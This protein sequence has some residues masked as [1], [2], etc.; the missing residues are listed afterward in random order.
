MT[1]KHEVETILTKLGVPTTAYTGGT[2]TSHSPITGEVIAQLPIT[3]EPRKSHSQGP[4]SL[5]PMA[6]RART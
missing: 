2:L 6:Q 5:P 4:R 1:L 3:A